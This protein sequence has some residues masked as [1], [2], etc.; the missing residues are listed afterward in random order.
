[1]RN[2]RLLQLG[3]LFSIVLYA[4]IAEIIGRAPEG[5]NPSVSYAFTTFGVAIVGVIFV[6]RRTLVLRS[7]E[8]L[9]VHPDDGLSLQHWKNG[10]IATYVLCEALALFGLVLRCTGSN[11]QQ[12][13]PFYVGGFILLFFFGPREPAR[14]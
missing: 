2:L 10:Y 4:G 14:S 11:F 3:M 6:V 7:A 13:L 8:S 5:G 12:G 9:A 1:V